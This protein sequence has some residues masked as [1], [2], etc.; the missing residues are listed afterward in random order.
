ME[1]LEKDYI[2]WAIDMRGCGESDK[3][4]S[5]YTVEQMAADVAAFIDAQ[6]IGQAVIVGHS[7]G[8]YIAQAL[9]LNHPA[10]VRKLVL[11]CTAPSGENN[12]GLTFGAIDAVLHPDITFEWARSTVDMLYG[13]PA[14]EPIRDMIA[15]QMLKA[16]R[17]A[18]LQQMANLTRINMAE[19]LINITAPTLV[20]VGKRDAFF[21]DASH[22]KAIPNMTLSLIHI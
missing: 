15:G 14:D 18:Y 7:M 3:M 12:P 9:A 17:D 16:C 5:G 2:T 8:G 19:R 20:I 22:F 21:P 1:A 13:E 4:R 10:R 11:T 6:K